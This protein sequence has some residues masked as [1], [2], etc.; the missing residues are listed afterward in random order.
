MNA[1]ESLLIGFLV[2]RFTLPNMSSKSSG[3]MTAFFTFLPLFFALSLIASFLLI[4][5]RLLLFVSTCLAISSEYCGLSG[6]RY[7]FMACGLG[8]SCFKIFVYICLTISSLKSLTTV[9]PPKEFI[10]LPTACAYIL[11]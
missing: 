9:P 2:S 3:F 11:S 4:R 7:L 6:S 1:S 8:L 5:F 10:S